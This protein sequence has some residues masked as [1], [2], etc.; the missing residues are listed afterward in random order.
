M[1]E[2]RN[3][4]FGTNIDHRKT[5]TKNDYVKGVVKVSRDL[6]TVKYGNFKFGMHIDKE[7]H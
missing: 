6:I 5:V 2:A 7:G 1:V 4:T 3:F